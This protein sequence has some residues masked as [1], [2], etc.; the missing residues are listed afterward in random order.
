[1]SII[2]MHITLSLLYYI[3]TY[4]YTVSDCTFLAY[5]LRNSSLKLVVCP[6]LISRFWNWIVSKYL[7][8]RYHKKK[9]QFESVISLTNIG[10]QSSLKCQPICF[11]T[12]I[13]MNRS[14]IK[15]FTSGVL[16]STDNE[17]EIKLSK[18]K[19]QADMIA[20]SYI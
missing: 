19:I 14:R 20:R 5:L 15:N 12:C 4:I 1:M 16:L 7:M 18:F 13:F 8:M 6:F 2:Q 9:F 17:F 3:I 11:E 10:D